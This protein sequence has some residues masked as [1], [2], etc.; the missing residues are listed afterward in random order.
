MFRII[1]KD[2]F[3]THN[4]NSLFVVLFHI[5]EQSSHHHLLY[6]E[7]KIPGLTVCMWGYFAGFLFS[8]FFKRKRFKTNPSEWKNGLDLDQARHLVMPDLGLSCIQR[9]STASQEGVKIKY[10][11]FELNRSLVNNYIVK[12]QISQ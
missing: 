10:L 4:Q 11:L 6:S 2:Y 12:Y 9:I 1:I 3:G 7:L 5:Q 8:V